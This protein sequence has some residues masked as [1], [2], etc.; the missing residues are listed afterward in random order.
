MNLL[1][2]EIHEFDGKK[3][4]GRGWESKKNFILCRLINK[5]DSNN[6]CMLVINNPK[7]THL[8]LFTK[9]LNRKYSSSL[10]YIQ[11]KYR[12]NLIDL[13]YIDDHSFYYW[14]IFSSS[15][16]CFNFTH[17]LYLFIVTSCFLNYYLFFFC[18]CWKLSSWKLYI[19]A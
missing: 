4:E 10:W 6:I 2:I 8:W 19:T 18:V 9:T 15:H 13:P 16:F 11:L 5:N 1:K 17:K 12:K 7:G 14:N 3:W